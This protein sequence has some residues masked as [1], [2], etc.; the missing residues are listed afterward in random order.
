CA[1]QAHGPL[2]VKLIAGNGAGGERRGRR[3]AAGVPGRYP[4]PVLTRAR[5]P[6]RPDSSQA[7]RPGKRPSRAARLRFS[8][9]RRGEDVAARKHALRPRVTLSDTEGQG[10][11]TPTRLSAKRVAAAPE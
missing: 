4:G 5:D 8:S 7:A 3:D 6:G 9:P 10:E 2:A 11:R 1:A